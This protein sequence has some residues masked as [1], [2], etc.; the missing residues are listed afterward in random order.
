MRGL[1]PSLVTELQSTHELRSAQTI[2]LLRAVLVELKRI[3]AN[4]VID[5]GSYTWTEQKIQT[6]IADLSSSCDH[7]WTLS[8]MAGQ[9]GI[10]RTQLNKIFHKLT[11]CTPMEYLFRIRMERAK[12]LL[13]ETDIKIIDIAFE[14]GYGTSQYFANTFKQATGTTPSAYRKHT[15]GLS[16][17]ESKDWKNIQFR[18][19][20]EE[21]ARVRDF[22]SS[23]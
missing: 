7:Q 6:L 21:R 3:I 18:S 16:A 2:T 12:T 20:E 11:G 4:E 1:M 17:A 22:S 14:C 23:D 10:Q 9:C 8:E 13:R 15:G 5:S 19:E